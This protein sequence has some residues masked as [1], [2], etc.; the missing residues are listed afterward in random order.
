MINAKKN[1]EFIIKNYPD[2]DFAIDS[3]F[4]INLINDILASKEMYLSQT[5]C[6]KRKM[7]T[8]NK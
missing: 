6:K 8:S 3:K 2:T 4:K 5:L 7:D 1:L